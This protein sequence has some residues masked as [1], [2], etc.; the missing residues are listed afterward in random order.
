MN[1][2]QNLKQLALELREIWEENRQSR[3]A[4]KF[5]TFFKYILNEDIQK[6]TRRSLLKN[7]T[8]Y[9]YLMGKCKGNN[10]FLEGEE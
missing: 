2:K 3:R 6:H 10:T 4:S 1:D 9:Q 7:L 5:E 8:E